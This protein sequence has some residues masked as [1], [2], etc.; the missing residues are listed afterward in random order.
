MDENL[1]L[2]E[3]EKKRLL[4]ELS[5][6]EYGSEEAKRYLEDLKELYAMANKDHELMNEEKRIEAEATAKAAALQLEH[7]KSVQEAEDKAKERRNNWIIVIVDGVVKIVV[8][9]AGI[10]I[11]S[12]N[13]GFMGKALTEVFKFESDGNYV[14]SLAGKGILG[15]L[16][17]RK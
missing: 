12:M 4:E 15:G 1:E 2:I 13:N 3:R 7:E 17:R 5:K 9:G 8:A 10:V 16:F 14:G 6:V 11:A